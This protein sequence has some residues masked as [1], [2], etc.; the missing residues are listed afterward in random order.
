MPA[1]RCRCGVALGVL[2]SA[3]ALGACELLIGIDDVRQ[4]SLDGAIPGGCLDADQEPNDTPETAVSLDSVLADHPQGASLYGMEI[5]TAEDVD[6]YSFTATKEEHATVLVQYTRDK[7]ELAADLLVGF[8][9]ELSTG[10]AVSGGLQL[11][12]TLQPGLYYL[13]VE[14]GPGG[15]TNL[16]DFSITFTSL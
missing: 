11:D 9:A 6:F 16:Y 15:S 7:G 4:G 12:A 14:A 8:L 10:V 1:A 2:A 13:R 5:C 3:L